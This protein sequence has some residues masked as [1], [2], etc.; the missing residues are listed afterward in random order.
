VA[1]VSATTVQLQILVETDGTITQTQAVTSSGNDAVDRLVGCL[2][3]E[4]LRLIPASSG[5]A[6]HRTDAFLLETRIRF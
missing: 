6:P 5:G 4:R 3:Q 2:V 1:T